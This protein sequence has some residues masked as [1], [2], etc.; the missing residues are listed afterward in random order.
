MLWAIAFKTQVPVGRRR[1][2]GQWLAPVT[3]GV[4]RGGH[5]YS[6]S[7]GALAEATGLTKLRLASRARVHARRLSTEVASVL[8][9]GTDR[10]QRETLASL[11]DA[12]VGAGGSTGDRP[13][14]DIRRRLPFRFDDGSARSR[15]GGGTLKDHHG[16]HGV[17]VRPNGLLINRAPRRPVKTPA[18][19][20][21]TRQDTQ[22]VPIYAVAGRHRRIGRTF[23][24]NPVG[25]EV[26]KVK[27]P[28]A[29]ARS[30]L[31]PR[32]RAEQCRDFRL[33]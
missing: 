10:R 20:D 11:Q 28:A 14:T 12:D 8:A 30:S 32:T 25:T 4:L 27:E 19:G 31:D 5:R 6:S 2:H 26:F 16:L 13:S 23:L 22:L 24:V 21:W 7:S 18:L 15:R 17:H 9:S 3:A 33:A 29:R 1:C